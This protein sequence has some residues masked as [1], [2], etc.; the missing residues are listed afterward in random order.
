MTY[1]DFR[2]ALRSLARR[3]Y[4][5]CPHPWSLLGRL[6]SGPHRRPQRHCCS[7]Q[8]PDVQRRRHK[9]SV[10]R[11]R[12]RD[13]LLGGPARI[14]YPSF[15]TGKAMHKLVMNFIRPH[16]QKARQP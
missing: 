11:Y 12:L 14:R 15:G 8:S 10:G 9:G 4:S 16:A 1:E 6:P 3:K 7:A 2:E 5:R 13:S